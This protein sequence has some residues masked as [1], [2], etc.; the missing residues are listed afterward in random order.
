[1]D[2]SLHNIIILLAC[3]A[4]VCSAAA[5]VLISYTETNRKRFDLRMAS[6]GSL[7]AAARSPTVM[8]R[9]ARAAPRQPTLLERAAGVFGIDLQRVKFY[10]VH[11][12]VL[13]IGTGI[14][15]RLMCYALALVLGPYAILLM[16]LIWPLLCRMVIGVIEGRRAT[17]LQ[18]QLPDVLAMIVR[19]VRVGVPV[20][21]ALRIVAREAPEPTA[22]EFTRIESEVAIG[23][24]LDESLKGM[25]ERSGVAEY[26]FFATTLTLQAQTGGALGETL[27]GLAE[28]IRKRLALRAKGQAMASQAKTSAIVL[29]LMPFISG[30]G[31]YFLNPN[32]IGILFTDSLG[33]QFLGVGIAMLSTG[34]LVMWSMINRSLA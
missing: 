11:P 9:I 26:K 8:R 17:L 2:F 28:V 16:A 23:G 31:M 19:S 1:M 20:A 10:S 33:Q 30:G 25:A 32:Y 21:E 3:V 4:L 5:G 12:A 29:G 18:A 24:A 6:V 22:T 15:A 13:L 14:G 27:Q 7:S 34:G